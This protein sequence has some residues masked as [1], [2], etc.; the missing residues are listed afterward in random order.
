[1]QQ[2]IRRFLLVN[3]LLS[4]TIT[5]SITAV[6]NYFLDE[7]DIQSHLD[8]FLEQ[9]THSFQALL[10]PDLSLKQIR[11][12]QTALDH[13]SSYRNYEHPRIKRIG[14]KFQFQVWDKNGH[15]ILRSPKAPKLPLSNGEIGFSHTNIEDVPWRVFTSTNRISGYSVVV[16]ER[17]DTRDDLVRLIAK[18]DLY[19]MLLTY[20][21]LGLL[22]WVVV[23]RGLSS[24][25]RVAEEVS[26]RAPNYLEPV[27]LHTVPVEIKGL[28]DELNHLLLR[29]QQGL[30]REKRFSADAAHEL[31][32]PLAA[33]KT[34]AQVALQAMS[35]DELKNALKKVIKGVD[36]STHVV[37]QLLTLSRL[38]P[39]ANVIEDQSRINLKYIVAEELALLAPLAIKKEIELAL[40]APDR[41]YPIMG[42]S[43]ALTILVKNLVDNAIRYSPK[44][45]KIHVQITQDE[46]TITF[47]VID[48]GPGIAAELRSRVFERFY[49]VL[50][51][52]AHGSGLGLAIVQQIANLHHA[53]V[54]LGSSQ[55]LKGLEV[56]IS[57]PKIIL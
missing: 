36:R 4:I 12:M 35:E 53:Q 43:A 42:N 37:E 32:T 57:F 13:L 47:K 20:P 49:R 50:G 25:H 54:K 7:K 28:V 15:L 51:T 40:V 24:I 8:A 1:M 34:Q 39:D 19:I 16:A 30:E 31:R 5:T 9:A 44:E 33:L 41:N 23:G 21:I 48:S 38:M 29:L 52:K 26:H 6:G 11:T 55:E 17:N 56:V 18:D 22:I 14:E 3:L 2:S 27:D 45:S 46:H 10:T